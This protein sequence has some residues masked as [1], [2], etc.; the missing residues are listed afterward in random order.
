M[1]S[2]CFDGGFA[3]GGRYPNT[4]SKYRIA[5]RL[6]VPGWDR[7][8]DTTSASSVETVNITNALNDNL[9][10]IRSDNAF[11]QLN[12]ALQ[13]AIGPFGAALNKDWTSQ[14][15]SFSRFT[16]DVDRIA[17]GFD[18]DFGDSTWTWNTYYQ[19]GNT[20]RQQ[21]VNDNKHLYAYYMAVDSVLMPASS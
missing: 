5:R 7:T 12:P 15:D 8:H 17:I 4:S 1:S 6:D 14:V 21:L 11:V 10:T 13:A 3:T 16:T 9:Q 2:G 20:D 19:Y 18:G